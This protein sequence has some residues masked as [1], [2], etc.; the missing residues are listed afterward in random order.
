MGSKGQLRVYPCGVR[1]VRNSDLFKCSKQNEEQF[2][3]DYTGKQHTYVLTT[4]FSFDVIL[5]EFCSSMDGFLPSDCQPYEALV[6]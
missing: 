4:M 2:I 5:S 3:R 6:D 1:H